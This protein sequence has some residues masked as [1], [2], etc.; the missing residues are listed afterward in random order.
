VSLK[1]LQSITIPDDEIVEL[2][3]DEEKEQYLEQYKKIKAL[4]QWI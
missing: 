3:V 4:Y 1:N 2:L